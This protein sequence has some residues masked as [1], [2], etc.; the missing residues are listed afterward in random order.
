MVM[1][2]K[3]VSMV[4]RYSFE[5]LLEDPS[6]SW[7]RRHVEVNKAARIVFDDHQHVK[8]SESGARN[9]AEVAGDDGGGVVL[10]KVDQR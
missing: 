3:P 10:E 5:Q 9:D 7:M 4:R 1:E 6:G 2:D 8:Q